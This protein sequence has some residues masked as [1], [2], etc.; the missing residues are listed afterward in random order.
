[1]CQQGPGG[2][3]AQ[4]LE[5]QHRVLVF[6]LVEFLFVVLFQQVAVGQVADFAANRE[7]TWHLVAVNQPAPSTMGRVEAKISSV[8]T[9]V[10]DTAVVE[11]GAVA[12]SFHVA[13]HSQQSLEFVGESAT[14]ERAAVGEVVGME[15]PV[16]SFGWLDRKQGEQVPGRP[17][18]EPEHVVLLELDPLQ[19]KI[20]IRVSGA[21]QVG[22]EEQRCFAEQQPVVLR[23]DPGHLVG[24]AAIGACGEP[25][26]QAPTIEEDVTGFEPVAGDAEG[27]GGGPGVVGVEAVFALL[28]DLLGPDSQRHPAPGQ[29]GKQIGI[30]HQAAVFP[31]VIECSPGTDHVAAGSHF[32]V[33]FHVDLERSLGRL[34][35]LR[36]DGLVVVGLCPDDDP[37]G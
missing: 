20:E 32:D 10:V 11:V 19:W 9:E 3:L 30:E 27:A 22:Q 31:G 4:L 23:M 24:A 16:D 26:G 33:A 2:V 25:A 28:A 21:S 14:D 7:A 1:M 17:G 37:V 18:L 6:L 29:F 35:E 5:T 12:P 8:E 36:G 15:R 34:D 13:G